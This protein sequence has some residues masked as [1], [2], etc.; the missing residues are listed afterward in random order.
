MTKPSP[1]HP[2]TPKDDLLDDQWTSLDEARSREE[3]LRQF[4]PREGE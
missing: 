1:Q 2:D 3:L 4:P